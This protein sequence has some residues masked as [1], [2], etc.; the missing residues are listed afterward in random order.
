VARQQ[1]KVFGVAAAAVAVTLP[2]AALL[3][4]RVPLVEAVI[5]LALC[6]MPVAASVAIL[7]YRL[8][9]IDLVINRT[10]VYG[11]LTA[12]LTAT[13][14]SS[15]AL[16]GA[17]LGQDAR[18]VTAGATLAVALAFR[19]LR[20]RLQD[21]VDRRFSRAR[22]DAVRRIA[23][24]LEALRAGAAAP[25]DIEGVLREVSSDPGLELR[26]FLPESALYVDAS[27]RPAAAT[28]SGAGS[29][30]AI[31]Y[32]G[33]PLAVVTFDPAS[34]QRELLVRVLD[35]SR[36]AIEIARLRV[37]L[38]RQLQEVQLSRSRIIAAGDAERRRVE[39]DLHDGAQ[40]RLV[41]IG[42]A[43]RH[44]QRKLDASPSDV[45]RTL[46][47]AV[48]EITI[49]IDELR[50]LARG[51]RPAQLDAGLAAA[52][53]E[54]A[55]RAPLPVVVHATAER[56]PDALENAAY[57]I[58]CEGLT[59]VVK[60]A[61]ASRVTMTA[62]HR[63][64]HLILEVVDDGIGG[65]AL[66]GGTGLTGLSDRIAAQGGTMRIESH[67]DGSGTTLRAELPCG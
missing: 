48:A 43:L 5:V 35:A 22:Y 15:A 32:G 34:G 20:A 10:L 1:L 8:Y 11:A 16:I 14:V 2:V 64:G 4:S 9:E 47:D 44:A 39:R 21:A 3:W 59:N 67:D 46:D 58:A 45:G 57:F 61:H 54:L 25:E 27:G 38:R 17:G 7:R 50:E 52:L 49:A 12:L 63:S 29:T 18:L 60:H 41:S 13:Y 28:A 31:D 62:E 42:L 26:Y 37:E 19:P 51:L 53:K 65:A 36:L 33:V 30:I 56:F 66:N 24:F 23:A 6:G 40:S 55:G